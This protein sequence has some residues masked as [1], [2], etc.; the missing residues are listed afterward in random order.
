MGKRDGEEAALLLS[1]QEATFTGTSLLFFS[2]SPLK[3]GREGAGRREGEKTLSKGQTAA[4]FKNRTASR[5]GRYSD[6]V[7]LSIVIS[8]GRSER[9]SVSHDT[10]T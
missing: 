8:S 4:S 6:I 3:R 9:E 10:S 1:S 5:S 2:L 7:S